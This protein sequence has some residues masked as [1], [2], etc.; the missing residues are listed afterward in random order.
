MKGIIRYWLID[1]N[2][3]RN[4]VREMENMIAKMKINDAIRD[5]FVLSCQKIMKLLGKGKT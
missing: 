3:V 2:K 1:I 5:N 4:N